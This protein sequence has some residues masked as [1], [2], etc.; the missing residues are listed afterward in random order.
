MAAPGFFE[1]RAAAQPL[2]DRHQTLMW[3]VGEL[4]LKWEALHTSPGLAAAEP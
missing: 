4:M 1:D 3:Q 2:V